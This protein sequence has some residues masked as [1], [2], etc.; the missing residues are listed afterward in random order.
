[1]SIVNQL[2]DYMMISNPWD[3]VKIWTCAGVGYLLHI[4]SM[5]LISSWIHHLYGGP[6]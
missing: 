3:Q 6:Y 5:L 1:M 4:Q 2:T